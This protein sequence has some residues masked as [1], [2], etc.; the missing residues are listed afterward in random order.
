[1]A[2]SAEINASPGA[3]RIVPTNAEELWPHRQK[4]LLHEINKEIKTSPLINGHDVFCINNHLG[5]LKNHPE[6]AY[7]PHRLASPQYSNQ[8]TAWIIEQFKQDPRL[9][10]RMREEYKKRR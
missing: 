1:M 2:I 3:V 10:K 6:F 4:D 8:Y 7:K 9:F 5:V